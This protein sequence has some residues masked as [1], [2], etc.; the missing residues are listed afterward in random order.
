MLLRHFRLQPELA[1]CYV[2]CD[3]VAGESMLI[4]AGEFRPEVCEFIRESG[5][6]L[7]SIFI[8]HSH[9]DHCQAL[10]RYLEA[11][12]PAEV[13]AGSRRVGPALTR[14]VGDGDLVSVGTIGGQ[15][16]AL[17][18]H[19]PDC[20]AL[21]FA[22]LRTV[23]TGDVLFA[24]S[25]GGTASP[26]DREQEIAGIRD[27]LLVLPDDVRIYSGHGP[28]TTVFIEKNGNPFLRLR[29]CG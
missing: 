18:G 21:Y 7:E 23:F 15:V 24:G 12:G 1:N 14:L 27:K 11:L 19:L 10:D 20:L 3:E 25:I 5:T 8:T 26:A 29:A 28:L 6:R 9:Y 22:E 4:D 2:L 17:P 13:L 16:L